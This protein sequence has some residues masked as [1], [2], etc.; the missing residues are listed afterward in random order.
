MLSI[1]A[2][3]KIKGYIG[4]M[5]LVCYILLVPNIT[6]AQKAHCYT[7]EHLQQQ[8]RVHPECIQLQRQ[9]DSIGN[10][11][12]NTMY[13]YGD[14][15]LRTVPVVFHIIHNYGSENISKQTI[16]D[17]M[18]TLND[19][20]RM[21]NSDTQYVRSIF[22]SYKADFHYKFV[23]ATIDPNGK[24]TDG[25]ERIYS[26]ETYQANDNVKKLA[27]WDNSKYLNVWVVSSINIGG[28]PGTTVLG[29]SQF[30]FQANT[31]SS[32]DG[33]VVIA[34]SIG[35]GQHTLVHEV[36]HWLGLYHPFQGGCY[37]GDNVD[38]TPPVDSASFGCPTKNNTCHNDVPDLLDMIENFMDYSDCSHLFTKGQKTWIDGQMANYRSGIYSSSNLAATGADGVTTASKGCVPV[39]DFYSNTVQV[40]SNSSVQ[41]VNNSY[42]TDTKSYTWRFSGGSPATDTNVNPIVNYKSSG[43]Y[44]VTLVAKNSNGTDSVIKSSYINVLPSVSSLKTPQS[45]GFEGGSLSAINYTT[46]VSTDGLKWKIT[47][48][49][50]ANGTHSIYLNNLQATYGNVY[51]FLLPPM[52]LSTAKSYT[53]WFN[54]AYARQDANSIDELEVTASTDCG[55]TFSTVFYKAGNRLATT[56][57]FYSGSVFAPASSDWKK[58]TASLTGYSSATSIILKFSFTNYGGNNIFI[59]DIN[60][61]V[62]TG[63][64]QESAGNTQISIYPNP[65]NDQIHIKMETVK[66]SSG[67]MRIYDALGRMVY[68]KN[69]SNIP[70]GASEINLSKQEINAQ[71]SGMYYLMM[72]TPEGTAYAKI[73]IE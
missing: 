32:T 52:D 41:F 37:G 21:R 69:I 25:I 64:E 9:A 46:P 6:L 26:T 29:Y 18:K 63:I 56:N 28:Q 44:N 2:M 34:S 23:M 15:T 33:V 8:F 11:S 47:T 40:C 13:K 45:E 43:Q 51:S 70:S 71:V 66:P 49:G 10:V 36:G 72:Q 73:I 20:Y 67:T 19:C 12:K 14:T 5:A 61:G 62:S 68:V 27:W 53:L 65:T 60:L 42:N 58:F 54:C 16:L 57:T 3:K 55:N 4:A 30:P 22:K 24:C 17:Q 50:A 35:S 59:D 38:D 31:A 7:D 48:Y 39:A 1:T